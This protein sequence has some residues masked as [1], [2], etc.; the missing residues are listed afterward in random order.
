MLILLL[1]CHLLKGHILI[2]TL[3]HRWTHL[4]HLGFVIAGQEGQV[5]DFILHHKVLLLSFEILEGKGEE[6][7]RKKEEFLSDGI[8]EKEGTWMEERSFKHICPQKQLANLLTKLWSFLCFVQQ[9]SLL[10]FLTTA[11]AEVS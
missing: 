4:G 3:T 1:K 8:I 6:R 7:V 5:V 11:T 9:R 10:V 2:N